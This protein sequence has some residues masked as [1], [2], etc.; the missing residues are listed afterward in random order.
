MYSSSSSSTWGQ[1]LL[2]CQNFGGE[3]AITVVLDTPLVHFVHHL[4]TIMDDALIMRVSLAIGR[5]DGARC[6][7]V[8]MQQISI[9]LS[10]TWSKPVI[11]QSIQ[12]K[13]LNSL[14]L[15]S[16]VCAIDCRF[17]MVRGRKY[18]ETDLLYS[19]KKFGRV[20]ATILAGNNNHFILIS[21]VYL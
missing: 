18:C 21:T 3:T 1:S 13:G 14:V 5:F 19:E 15:S 8:M 6:P 16:G 2:T 10:F 11:S 9:I 17:W 12:T 7:S 4:G 20:R